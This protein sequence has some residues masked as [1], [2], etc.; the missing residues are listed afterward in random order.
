M[1][2][3]IHII[4]D[5]GVCFWMKCC[6]CNQKKEKKEKKGWMQNQTKPQTPKAA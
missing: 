1:T 4:K 3:H 2:L 5:S 6:C